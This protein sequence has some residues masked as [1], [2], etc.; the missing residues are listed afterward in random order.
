MK[1]AILVVD[2]NEVAFENVSRFNQ[3]S[4]VVH[5]AVQG[6]FD[7]LA[8]RKDHEYVVLFGKSR[9]RDVESR[10]TGSVTYLAIPSPE[11][12]LPGMRGYLGRFRALRN[13]L[14]HDFK[15]DLVHAQGTERESGMV[16][17]HAGF[18][19][20]ITLHG[21]FRELKKVYRPSPWNYYWINSHLET[22]VLKRIDGIVCISRYVEALTGTFGKRQFLIPNPV[23]PDFLVAERPARTLSTR[24]VCCM[25]ALDERKRP[26]FIFEACLPLWERGEDFVLHVYG[27][28]G[29]SYHADF[30]GAARSWVESGRVIF[31]GFTP[32]PLQA[33]LNS[34]VM[35]SASL[36]ESF[37]MNVL[38]AM[39]AGTPVVA[40]RIG[41]IADIVE[42]GVSG[43]L[44]DGSNRSECTEHIGRLLEDASLW[45]RI[46]KAGRFRARTLFSPALIAEKTVRCYEQ[47]VQ[48]EARA[49]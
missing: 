30:L 24:H 32:D 20:L 16:A 19:S 44:F 31:E 45:E 29:G 39:A 7:A 21:N 33:I 6:L 1:I 42:D 4:P 3:P 17:V 27:R 41:G 2:A 11:F 9:V 13:F 8:K 23:R 47:M 48:R 40:P 5:P 35:V 12:S 25:G 10:K 15:P 22:H 46:S 36:E 26:K 38:E 37:G 49:S 34:D 43:L 28:L 14:K 18:P